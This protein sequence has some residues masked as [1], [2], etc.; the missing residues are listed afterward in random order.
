[1]TMQQESTQPKVTGWQRDVVLF[2]DRQIYRLAKHWLAVLN[3]VVGIYVLLP[4]LAPLL[5][6]S[7][8]PAVGRILYLVYRPACHQLPE[9]SF[10]VFGPQ[11]TY[12]L[13]E[14]QA[15]GAISE[16]DDIFAR[17]R[18]LGALSAGYK[19][20]LC[21]RDMALYGS[22]LLGGLI[23]G[24][25]GKRLRPLPLLAFVLSLIPMAID[26]GTQL[27]LARESTPL[28]R[29]LTGGL[30]G[31]VAVWTL[32]PRLDVAFQDVRIQ[33]NERVHLE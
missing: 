20:A 11:P 26:G 22:I 10:F 1:M 8:A 31:L 29:L 27:I 25:L 14:L 7:G 12:T 15:L 3:L 4:L 18:F 5:M 23:Y 16:T 24:L 2:L 9:R 21:Q 32:Y 19:M 17:Q 28:L 13:E 33:A 6:V 30:V